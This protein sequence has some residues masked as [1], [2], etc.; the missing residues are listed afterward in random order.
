VQIAILSTQIISLTDG[1]GDGVVNYH[2]TDDGGV[3]VP[4]ASESGTAL[5]WQTGGEVDYHVL[6]IRN[7]FN[8]GWVE[9]VRYDIGTNEA[10]PPIWMQDQMDAI[11]SR[12]DALEAA[13]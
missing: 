7:A 10:L 5:W 8:D 1:E 13:E 6:R 12:L 11:L 4:E 2:Y 9:L 3:T